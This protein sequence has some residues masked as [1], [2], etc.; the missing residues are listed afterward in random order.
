MTEFI[1]IARIV[2]PHGVRGD[3]RAEVITDFPERFATTG[4]V[5]VGEPPRR[6][7]LTA[8]RLA[9]RVVLL[10]L[11]GVE[12]R[13]QAAALAGQ[14]VLVPVSEA[15]SL[16]PGQFFWHQIVGLR[17]E[18][19]AGATLG[20]VTQVLRTG[21]NDVYAVETAEG[22]LLLPAIRQVVKA[23]E[24]ERG[25]M[26]VELLPGLEPERRGERGRPRPERRRAD[27]ARRGAGR[28]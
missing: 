1:E 7:A 10:H 6:Y 8:T 16:P 15:V 11:E 12:T 21:G 28:S 14:P 18:T 27:G 3:V 19:T 2:A 13:E 20:R 22:E 25:R 23:I 9:G 4:A 5:Y 17:V 26:V 24:P